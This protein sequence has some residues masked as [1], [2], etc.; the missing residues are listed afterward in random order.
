M[1]FRSDL[2]TSALSP[3]EL[4]G[5]GRPHSPYQYQQLSPAPKGG[6]AMQYLQATQAA[7]G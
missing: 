3:L 2:G 5:L 6:L 4:R 7:Q 1:G